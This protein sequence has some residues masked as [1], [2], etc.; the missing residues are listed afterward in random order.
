MSAGKT[1]TIVEITGHFDTQLPFGPWV[2]DLSASYEVFVGVRLQLAELTALQLIGGVSPVFTELTTLNGLILQANQDLL[3]GLEGV[4][5][6]SAGWTLASGQLFLITGGTL[7]SVNL[8]NTSN[9]AA[10]IALAGGGS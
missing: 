9:V 5:A 3:I 2:Y 4:D 1:R 8:Y 10:A 7:T 6:A